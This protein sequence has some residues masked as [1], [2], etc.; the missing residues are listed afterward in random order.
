M[1]DRRVLLTFTPQGQVPLG[2]STGFR[3]TVD[4]S[5]ANL[6]PNEIFRMLRRPINP[7]DQDT[8]VDLF[9]GVC[10]PGELVTLPIDDPTEDSNRLLRV[11]HIDLT[12]VTEVLALE[13]WN[14]I[15]ADANILKDNLDAE[16]VLD[17]PQEVWIGTPP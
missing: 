13:A 7:N 1:S 16:D 10:L 4:A 11:D 14:A 17:V 12:L 8:E 3:F 15:Q 6:M 2:T 9:Q 5:D